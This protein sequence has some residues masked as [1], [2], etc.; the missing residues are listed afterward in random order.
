MR[1]KTGV[2]GNK[3]CSKK[4]SSKKRREKS[5]ISMFLHFTYDGKGATINC[6]L[7]PVFMDGVCRLNCAG[8]SDYSIGVFWLFGFVVARAG[9]CRV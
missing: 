1:A 3:I 9:V 2:F 8:L 5:L 7:K 6:K 4:S